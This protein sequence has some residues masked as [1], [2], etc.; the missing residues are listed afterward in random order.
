MNGRV[1][2]YKVGRFLSVDPVIQSPGNS[3]SINPYSYIM[4]NP[5]AG[6]DPTGYCSVKD[7]LSDCA[8]S[9]DEGETRAITNG[10]KTVGYVGKDANG[11]VYMTNNGAKAGQSAIQ[12]TLAKAG[13]DLTD[14]NGQQSVAKRAAGGGDFG[15]NNFVDSLSDE[16]SPSGFNG[17]ETACGDVCGAAAGKINKVNTYLKIEGIRDVADIAV[18]VNQANQ[19]LTELGNKAL[20]GDEEAYSELK[21]IMKA[22]NMEPT[23]IPLVDA[24]QSWSKMQTNVQKFSRELAKGALPMVAGEYISVAAEFSPPAL[25]LA[26]EGVGFTVNMTSSLPTVPNERKGLVDWLLNGGEK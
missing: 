8:G 4:N 23:G 14:L 17:T 3:Q 25:K 26:L 18:A 16:S 10:D 21:E 13:G 6:T 11:N 5:L 15:T 20:K 19:Y 2:D 22:A 9:L 12:G 7:T 1:Y 24:T